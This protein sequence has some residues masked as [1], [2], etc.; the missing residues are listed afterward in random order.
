MYA[1]CSGEP[2]FQFGLYVISSYI[3]SITHIHSFF[4]FFF[5]LGSCPCKGVATLKEQNFLQG[6]VGGDPNT[7]KQRCIFDIAISFKKSWNAKS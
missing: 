5:L 2:R 6:F 1:F 7:E 3:M 4:L